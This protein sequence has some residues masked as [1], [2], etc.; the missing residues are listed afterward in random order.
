MVVDV[1]IFVVVAGDRGADERRACLTQPFA[2]YLS[3]TMAW[4]D[5]SRAC[6]TQPFAWYLSRTVAW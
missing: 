3:R 4:A 6:L 5:E 2:W 1:H